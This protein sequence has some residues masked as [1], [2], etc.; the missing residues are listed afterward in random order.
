MIPLSS[1]DPKVAQ[2]LLGELI[3]SSATIPRLWWISLLLI[4][5]WHIWLAKILAKIAG[6]IQKNP[7]SSQG[8]KAKIWY[9][10]RTCLKAEW[11]KRAENSQRQSI[12]EFTM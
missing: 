4:T 6:V 11:S 12:D 1:I 7:E 9:Q 3:I 8:T 5:M 2:A 10:L